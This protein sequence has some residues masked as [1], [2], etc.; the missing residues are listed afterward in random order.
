MLKTL[1]GILHSERGYI[2]LGM[3]SMA[4]QV[5]I[6]GAI[7]GLF[8]A[9]GYWRNIIGRIKSLKGRKGKHR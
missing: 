4:I 6:A 9:K 8:I 3:G 5:L 2:D 7:G 1:L